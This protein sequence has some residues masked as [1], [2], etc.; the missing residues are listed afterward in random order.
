[1]DPQPPRGDLAGN[2]HLAAGRQ[3]EDLAAQHVESLGWTLLARNWRCPQGEIDLIAQEPGRHGAVVFVEVKC[4]RG[5][6]YGDPLESITVAKQR[7]LR[8]LMQLWL[9]QNGARSVIRLDAVGVLLQ[10]D[11]AAVIDHRRGILQ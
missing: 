6:G 11:R 5:T 8:Q 10:H 1:M 9:R 4:R 3:G 2:D 7:K